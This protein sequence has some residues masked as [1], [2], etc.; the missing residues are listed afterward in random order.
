MFGSLRRGVCRCRD[1]L[2]DLAVPGA[3]AQVALDAAPDGRL[4]PGVIAL[5]QVACL[6][7][8]ARGAETALHRAVGDEG[9]AQP[10]ARLPYDHALDGHQLTP[11]AVGREHEA[12]IYRR[13]VH[14]D[15]AGTALA[16]AAAVLGAGEPEPLA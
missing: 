6:H 1:R 11:V 3:A 10:L 7:H 2:D 12:G 5:D 13:P 8:Q 16:L 15:G 4:V 9:L 14:D